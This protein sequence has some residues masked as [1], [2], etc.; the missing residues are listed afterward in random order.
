MDPMRPADRGISLRGRP[1][2]STITSVRVEGLSGEL[3]IQSRGP[4]APAPPAASAPSWTRAPEQGPG[5]VSRGP[6][7]ADAEAWMQLRLCLP[8]GARPGAPRGAANPATSA[9]DAA[10]RD[11]VGGGREGGFPPE[12]GAELGAWLTLHVTRHHA[13]GTPARWQWASGLTA[14]LMERAGLVDLLGTSR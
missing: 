13:Q 6:E 4:M 8:A 9:A 10:L 1:P 2:C 7:A 11:L 12:L 5:P 3:W 14:W